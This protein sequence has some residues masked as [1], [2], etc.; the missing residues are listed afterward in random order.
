MIVSNDL[1][2]EILATG[3]L[4]AL[5][6]FMRRSHKHVPAAICKYMETRLYLCLRTFAPIVTAHSEKS[7]MRNFL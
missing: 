3:M 7:F 5:K 2:Q 4:T 1:S 6:T